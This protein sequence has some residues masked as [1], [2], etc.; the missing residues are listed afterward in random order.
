VIYFYNYKNNALIK[1][2]KNFIKQMNQVQTIKMTDFETEFSVI[3]DC[4]TTL[5]N[6]HNKFFDNKC[7]DNCHC[8]TNLQYVIKT[9]Y[10][11]SE[12]KRWAEVILRNNASL[13]GECN[14]I[15]SQTNIE[16]DESLTVIVSEYS[17]ST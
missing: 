10:N 1:I 2:D 16:K 3:L 8:K 6:P 11:K 17:R 5:S 12:N 14:H 15:W 9:I 4:R 13:T 7:E